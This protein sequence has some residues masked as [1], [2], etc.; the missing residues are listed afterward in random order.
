MSLIAFAA[1]EYCQERG[2]T[3]GLGTQGR[4]R[5]PN[6]KIGLHNFYYD[7]SHD[8]QS[9]LDFGSRWQQ[10]VA[11]SNMDTDSHVKFECGLVKKVWVTTAGV[12]T[13]AAE[14]SGY[15]LFLLSSSKEK[16]SVCSVFSV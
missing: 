14:T 6:D 15:F 11:H 13:Q 2:R 4:F 5:V 1:R 8:S 7:Y 3:S 12:L 16:A 10:L 9:G